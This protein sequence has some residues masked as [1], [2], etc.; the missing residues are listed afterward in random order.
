MVG[1]Q[2]VGLLCIFR[3]QQFEIGLPEGVTHHLA[4]GGLVLDN[5]DFCNGHAH[6]SLLRKCYIILTVA[7]GTVLIMNSK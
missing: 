7:T 3:F 6:A 4:D 2:F 5:E 1:N